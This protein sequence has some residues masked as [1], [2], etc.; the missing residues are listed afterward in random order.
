MGIF[1]HPHISFLCTYLGHQWPV[2][3]HPELCPLCSIPVFIFTIFEKCQ[4]WVKAVLWLMNKY[5]VY[6]FI[7]IST[8][9]HNHQIWFSRPSIYSPPLSSVFL[10]LSVRKRAAN[11]AFCFS[12]NKNMKRWPFVL[13]LKPV[14]G[15]SSFFLCSLRQVAVATQSVCFTVTAGIKYSLWFLQ[16]KCSFSFQISSK[17]SQSPEKVDVAK[18]K[19]ALKMTSL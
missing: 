17:G 3:I 14:S 11:P 2:K 18:N 10:S 19:K 12:V 8:W 5:S 13:I 4:R 6:R 15:T 16:P 9:D 7:F 1:Q